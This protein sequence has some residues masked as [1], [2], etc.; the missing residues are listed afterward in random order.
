MDKYIKVNDKNSFNMARQ[1]IKKEGL[2]IGGSSG[3]AMY[4]A[5]KAAK[6]LD[7]NQSCLVVLPDSIRNYLSKFIDDLE[8]LLSENRVFR[9]FWKDNK[10]VYSSEI[11]NCTLNDAK[12]AFVKFIN[13]N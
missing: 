2:L 11:F 8:T 13:K 5:I 4:A 10:I 1:L 3:T 6:I 7:K 12:L 9:K